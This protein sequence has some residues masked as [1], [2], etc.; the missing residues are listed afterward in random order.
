M[1][2]VCFIFIIC[3]S[4]K[5]DVYAAHVDQVVV[6][7]YG[8]EKTFLSYVIG[9]IEAKGVV[10]EV[11]SGDITVLYMILCLAEE[12]ETTTD[13]EERVDTTM[14]SQTTVGGKVCI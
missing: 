13:V 3:A 6:D 9:S 4:T 5:E 11:K 7:A 12:E 1:V 10:G 8:Q 2:G 14:P